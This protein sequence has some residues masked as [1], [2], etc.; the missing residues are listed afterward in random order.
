MLLQRPSPEASC[1]S[2]H[3][4]Y[5]LKMELKVAKCRSDKKQGFRVQG[6]NAA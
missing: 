4:V 6:L 1:L 3:L 2:V 5:S